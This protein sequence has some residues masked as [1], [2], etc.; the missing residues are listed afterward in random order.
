MTDVTMTDNVTF[1]GTEQEELAFYRR[2]YKRERILESIRSL[3]HVGDDIDE[4]IK[5]CVMALAL[6]GCEPVWSCCGFD[7]DGQPLHK[8]HQ[9]GASGVV[10][11]ETPRVEWLSREFEER[12]P[13][14]QGTRYDLWKIDKYN[15]YSRDFVTFISKAVGEKGNVWPDIESIHYSEPAVICIAV[16]ESW[17]MG[18]ILLMAEEVVLRSSN[19]EFRNRFPAWQYPPLPDWT[20]TKDELLERTTRR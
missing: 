2:I 19:I 11:Y 17:L 8:S 18:Y 10:C 16:L 3:R 14:W 9:Y 20:V 5:N 15:L 12:P 6:L 13:L 4:P 7:Y 1:S